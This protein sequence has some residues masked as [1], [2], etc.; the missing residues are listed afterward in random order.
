MIGKSQNRTKIKKAELFLAAGGTSL[1]RIF[2]LIKN[3][4][5]MKMK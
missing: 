1:Y 2:E 5:N 4:M 3:K